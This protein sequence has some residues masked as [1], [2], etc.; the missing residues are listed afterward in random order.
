[1]D[2]FFAV[3]AGA[4]R[5][6]ELQLVLTDAAVYIQQ[7]RALAVVTLLFAIRSCRRSQQSRVRKNLAELTEVVEDNFRVAGSLQL[8]GVLQQSIA[9]A[10]TG[11]CPQLLLD[12]L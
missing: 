8:S 7:V 12:R 4:V 10:V 11:N 3:L 2:R 6:G 1:M 5:Y 9:K